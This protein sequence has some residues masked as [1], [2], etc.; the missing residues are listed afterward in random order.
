MALW[1][2]LLFFADPFDTA[3]RAGI[4]AL[5]QNDL[6]Q[7]RTQLESASRIQPGNPR[8]WLALA[9]TYWK[10]GKRPEA[11]EAARKAETS[12]PDPLVLHGLSVY[13]AGTTN[14]GKAAQL[15][16]RY[17]A[18]AP[19]AFSRAL[20]LYLQAG[21]FPAAIELGRRATAAQNT[22][23]IHNLLGKAYEANGDAAGAVPEYQ[24][25]VE[26]NRFNEA[27]YFDLAQLLLKQQKFAAALESLEAAR[28]YFDKSAQLELAT[29]VT[30]YGLR[31]FPEA[32]DSFL[33]TIA[34]DP[35]VEQPYVFLGRMLDQAEDRMPRVTE[36]FATFARVAP[37][38][39]LSSFLYGKALELTE[40]ERADGLLRKSIAQEGGFWESHFEL[41]VLLER[42]GSFEEAAREIRRSVELNPKEAAP[43]YRLAR[44]YQRLGNSEQARLE[45]EQYETRSATAKVA[46]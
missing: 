29:G 32:I 16:A 41:G 34:L 27:Y 8:V 23:E 13:Y 2:F 26:I 10:L 28:K 17:A 15:E 35:R 11:E 45:R 20:Q 6:P 9:Q 42:R 46:K 22:A 30:Y 39:H 5:N 1:L 3:F 43:H 40:P 4:L 24:R 36:A 21:Q 19:D 7:A 31:R 37:D 44:L 25:A 38:N 18:T 14:Y 33:R 12:N